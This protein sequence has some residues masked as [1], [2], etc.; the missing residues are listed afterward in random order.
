M[1]RYAFQLSVLPIN[2]NLSEACSWKQSLTRQNVAFSQCS[3]SGLWI[4][5]ATAVKD[6]LIKIQYPIIHGSCPTQSWRPVL[7]STFE[8]HHEET[9]KMTVRPAKTQIS[10]GIRPVWSESLLCAQ[11]VAEDPNFFMGTAKTLIRLGGCPGWSES[12]LVA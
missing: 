10:L 12:L 2:Q 7:R 11:C 5:A 3:P 6:Q 1:V 9:N 4:C 8:P